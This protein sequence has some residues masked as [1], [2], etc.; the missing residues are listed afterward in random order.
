[1]DEQYM[2][3]LLDCL[4]SGTTAPESVQRETVKKTLR[5]KPALAQRLKDAQKIVDGQAYFSFESERINNVVK[6][7][8]MG[9]ALYELN[10]ILEADEA[11]ISITPLVMFDEE[12]QAEFEELRDSSLGLWPEC[13][14]RLLQRIAANPSCE[15][16][17]IEV[18]PGRYRYAVIQADGVEVRMVFSEYLAC[19][20]RWLD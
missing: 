2:A 11:E 9:H 5:A 18:Q 3:C 4:I 8:A 17:W 16:G 6:K 14:S 13:G 12:Q 1:M 19:I 7:I 20:V 15:N 10:L